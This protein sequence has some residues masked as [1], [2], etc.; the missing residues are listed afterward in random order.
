MTLWIKRFFYS[1][2]VFFFCSTMSIGTTHALSRFVDG[3]PIYNN[4]EKLI[5]D[6]IPWEDSNGWVI[7]S[8]FKGFRDKLKGV[9]KGDISSGA[10]AR[11]KLLD[12]IKS[13]INYVL[14]FIGLIALFYL[15]YHGLVMLFNPGD[16]A[17]VSD[18]WKA[19][20]YATIAIVWVGVAWFLVS[21]IFQVIG[22]IVKAV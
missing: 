12:L 17:K 13:I 7:R 15:I 11:S 22:V 19:I 9:W 21:I 18:G 6:K 2:A 5:V 16:D 20:R 1:M 14:G 3:N 8:W 4:D 10:D